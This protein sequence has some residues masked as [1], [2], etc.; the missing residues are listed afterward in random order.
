M[1]IFSH[2]L[3]NA[4]VRAAVMGLKDAGLLYEFHTSV[5]SFEGSTLH[6]LGGIGPFS[7]IRRRNFHSLLKP[8][9]RTWPWIE[10][11]RQ[12]ALK[13]GLSKLTSHETGLYCVDAVYRCIDKRVKWRLSKRMDQVHG[14]FAY[15]DGA[16]YSFR[17]AKKLRLQCLYDLPIGYWRASQRLLKMEEERWPD[18]AATLETFKDSDLKLALK[19][20]ELRLADRIFVASTFTANTLKEF[21]G[22]LAPIEVIPYGFPPVTEERHYRQITKKNKL[23]LLFVGSLSQ[24]KGLADIFSAV[25]HLSGHVELTVVGL[26]PCNDCNVLEKGLA[27]HTWIPKLPHKD[28][29]EMMKS[30]DVLI[31]PSLFE[32]FGLVITEAMSQGTPVITT[33]RTAG[34]DLITHEENGWLVNAGST[35]ALIEAIENLL[36]SPG[37]IEA[38]G[39][40]AM[41]TARLRPWDVYKTELAVSVQKHFQNINR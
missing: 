40:A 7:E 22:R 24:R 21:P 29:L 4:N 41:E 37:S 25:E 6:R 39:R 8:Y 11:G 2:P 3:G 1:I 27:K 32:G 16:A 36:L 18:W 20:E 26:K 35:E 19:D 28:I 34:P 9:T 15:E 14:V 13:A 38:A 31:F 23:K 33:D 12:T 30:C 17:E 10:I 5:A